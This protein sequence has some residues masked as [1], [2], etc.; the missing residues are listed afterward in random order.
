M[1]VCRFVIIYQLSITLLCLL[2][3]D[4]ISFLLLYFFIVTSITFIIIYLT[5]WSELNT[6]DL[7]WFYNIS[8]LAGIITSD[9]DGCSAGGC[10]CSW[11]S[12]VDEVAVTVTVSSTVARPPVG[13]TSGPAVTPS[14][15]PAVSRDLAVV[16]PFSSDAGGVSI[17]SYTRRDVKVKDGGAATDGRDRKDGVMEGQVKEERKGNESGKKQGRGECAW[18]GPPQT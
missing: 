7:I 14:P 5:K 6:F 15:S 2:S 9:E 13:A 12:A 18:P 3:V 17:R 8:Q 1:H 11:L 10:F 4:F 16:L